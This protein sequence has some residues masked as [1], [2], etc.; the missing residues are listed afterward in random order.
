MP[1]ASPKRESG[2]RSILKEHPRHVDALHYLGVLLHQRGDNEGAAETTSIARWPSPHYAACWSNRGL[3]AAAL[4]D[5][6]LRR[7]MPASARSP[8]ILRLPTRVTILASRCRSKAATTEAIDALPDGSLKQ[9]DFIDAHIEPRRIAR[10]LQSATTKR[11]RVH[12]EA[13]A[14]D[15]ANSDAH[16]GEGNALRELGRLDDAIDSLQR[17]ARIGAGRTSNRA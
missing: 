4:G 12:R 16:F 3:V 7:G 2:Y 15:P 11:W 1:A 17:A 8:S 10:E 13:L 9:P 6:A 5:S 14:H